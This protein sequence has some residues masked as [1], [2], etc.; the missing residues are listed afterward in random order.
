VP[1]APYIGELRIGDRQLDCAVLED[2][3]RVI[4][5]TTMQL[6]LDR[7]GGARRG[8]GARSLPLLSALNLQKFVSDELREIATTPIAY[9]PAS[10]G[11]A[12]GYPAEILPMVCEVYLEAREQRALTR[13]QLPVARAAELLMR[14][15]ARVGIVALVDEATGYQEVRARAELQKILEAYVTAEFRPWTKMFPDEFFEQIYRLQGWEYRP[16]TA[17]RTQFVGHLINRYIYEQLP[18]G[19]REELN[20]LNPRNAHGNRVRRFHQ[21]LTADTGNPHLDKQISTVTTL[22]RISNSQHEFRMLFE[23]AFPPSIPRLPLVIEIPELEEARTDNRP[24]MSAGAA[25]RS[26]IARP[27]MGEQS[28]FFPRMR[29]ES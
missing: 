22:M 7:T 5:Q 28:E 6:A 13:N 16:G 21:F 12:F 8:P 24:P 15:L 23:R 27:P 19:V 1:A 20:R 29:S 2:G 11:K 18:T 3:T 10:G 9:R 25:A 4:N 14:G 17:K 26:D